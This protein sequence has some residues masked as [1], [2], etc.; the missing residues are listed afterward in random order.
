MTRDADFS[1]LLAYALSSGTRP[2]IS[3][4]LLQNP[5]GLLHQHLRKETN[6]LTYSRALAMAA[7]TA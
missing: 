2:A 5:E 1:L 3:K 4:A 7:Y 6:L